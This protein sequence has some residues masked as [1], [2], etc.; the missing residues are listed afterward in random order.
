MGVLTPESFTKSTPAYFQDEQGNYI[1]G[2]AGGENGADLYASVQKA[3]DDAKAEG[4]TKIVGLGHLGV[5]P[6]SEPWTSTSTIANTSGLGHL[7][8]DPSSEPWT[9]TSTIANTSGFDAFIDGHSHSELVGNVVNDKEG[10]PVVVA[11]TGSYFDNIGVVVLH[12]DGTVENGFFT[13]NAL[14]EPVLDENG[15]P[16]KDD[17]GNE[18]TQIVGYELACDVI[19]GDSTPTALWR[20]A[21]SPP[22]P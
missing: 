8:V 22:T 20:T 19:P 5:D 11:Q 3:I 18:E 7:G 2:I 13:A 14:T 17:K 9:S 10:K 1:Y 16:K 15:N 12:A 6:S 21:S 4:A